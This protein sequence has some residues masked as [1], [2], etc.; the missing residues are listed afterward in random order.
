MKEEQ[1]M[2]EEEIGFAP[3]EEPAAEDGSGWK[4]L[5][6]DDDPDIHRVTRLVLGPET[7]EGRPLVFYSAY[8]A[9]EALELLRGHADFAVVLLDVVME[10]E[11]AGLRLARS[12]RE[13]LGNALVR[14][15][16]RTGQ[17]GQAPESD[18]IRSYDI[19]DYRE[20]TE[21]TSSKLFSTVYAS[22]RAYRAAVELSRSQSRLEEA[23]R[24]RTQEL[25]E[26]GRQLEASIRSA[27][28]AMAEVA[29]LEERGRIAREIHHSVGHTMTAA[30]VQLEAARRLLAA[31]EGD[32][33]EA[34]VEIARQLARKGLE[35]IR[36]SVRAIAADSSVRR[37]A[38]EE[39]E[40][41]AR[42]AEWASGVRVEASFGGL[43]PLSWYQARLLRDILREGLTNG[44]R[45]GGA[46]RFACRAEVE[47][48]AE[49]GRRIAL[50]LWNDGR[51]SGDAEPGFG[52]RAL[53]GQL[54]EAG[55]SLTLAASARGGAELRAALPLPREAAA[56]GEAAEAAEAG[57]AAV[58]AEET[59]ETADET[60]ETA[61]SAEETASGARLRTVLPL[62]REPEAA[63]ALADGVAPSEAGEACDGAAAS[64]RADRSEPRS[65]GG[66]TP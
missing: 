47:P 49:G 45:H 9:A 31:G 4:F 60:A 30:I 59:A 46:Q 40:Q 13:E 56:A 26:R 41:V 54:A 62:S 48:S 52:L 11:D 42:E 66:G 23:V 1:R 3:E 27:Y 20:K 51:W 10:T 35:E 22:V 5:I 65:P 21:L 38:G 15:V 18:V 14:I 50:S 37:S 7:F 28:E 16:L 53:Q 19:N 29:V 34:K 2:E 61:A 25:E 17:P 24:R 55:G 39:L 32:E 12:I 36:G 8:S 43:P 64:E 6:V 33:A 44:I 57:E 58:S 63:T